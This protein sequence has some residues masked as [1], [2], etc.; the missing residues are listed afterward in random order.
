MLVSMVVG[1]TV[2]TVRPNAWSELPV[3]ILAPA[4][5]VLPLPLAPALTRTVPLVLGPDGLWVRSRV[6]ALSSRKCAA[7]LLACTRMW[8][9]ELTASALL[10]KVATKL[11]RLLALPNEMIVS[12]AGLECM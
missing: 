4:R 8:F 6:L 5:R 9:L 7:P 1:L 3:Y 2:L 11:C 12:S 10:A